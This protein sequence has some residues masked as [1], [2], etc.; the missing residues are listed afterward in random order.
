MEGLEFNMYNRY[1][2]I[3]TMRDSDITALYQKTED[4]GLSGIVF[5]DGS[6][7][8]ASEF[9]DYV[10][11]PAVIFFSI[12]LRGK[13]FGYF[14][15]NRIESTHAYCHFMC[16]PE[17]WGDGRTVTVGQEAMKICLK[18]FDMI[19]GMLPS[20]NHFAINYLLKVGLHKIGTIPN[21][22]WSESEQKPVEGTMLYITAEDLE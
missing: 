3:P 22:I 17:F 20:T 2:G 19:M 21:L 1:D 10:T 12:A 18:E 9:V 11:T 7:R 6:I 5:D 8:N 14:W 15:L 4:E 16:F 13:P